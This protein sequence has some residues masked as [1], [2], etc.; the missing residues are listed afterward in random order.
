MWVAV[1]EEGEIVG[2][3]IART[4]AERDTK[5]SRLFVL[6]EYGEKVK[7]KLLEMF[8]EAIP[9]IGKTKVHKHVY[10]GNDEE[11]A[12][13]QR[14]GYTFGRYRGV[15]PGAEEVE[16]QLMVKKLESKEEVVIVSYVPEP[17]SPKRA[18]YDYI[19]GKLRK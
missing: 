17:G 12:F 7:V 3:L 11:I 8:E 10:A 5:C 16:R 2:Y 4:D 6:P 15:E 1:N 19:V 9:R 13:L 14:Q 18:V